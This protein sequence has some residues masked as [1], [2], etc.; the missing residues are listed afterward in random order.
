LSTA[1]TRPSTPDLRATGVLLAGLVVTSA[2]GKG[3]TP[4][5]LAHDYAVGVGL[6]ILASLVIDYRR[7]LRN[8]V[9]ADLMAIGSLYFLT[10]FEFLFPQPEFNDLVTVEEVL[11]ALT[12]CLL[13]FAGLAI[14]RHLAPAAPRSLQETLRRPIS[15]QT[16]IILYTVCF[17]GGY[18]HMLLAVDF[19]VFEMIHYFMTPRFTQPW[20]R[21]KYGDWKALIG[22]LGMVLY[23]I[24]PIAGIVLAKRK[25]F[26]TGQKVY[27][28]AAFLFTLF[29]GFT[30]GTRNIFATYL[31]TFLVANAFVTNPDKKKELVGVSALTGVLMLAA[32]VVM[33]EF[34]T[35]GFENYCSGYRE[36]QEKKEKTTFFVDYNLYV[37]AKLGDVF[38]EQHDFLGWEIPYLAIIRPIPRAIW[39]GKPEGLSFSIE[40]AVG[41]KGLTLASSFV[42]EAYISGGLFGV[43]LTGLVFGSIAGWWNRLGRPDNSAFGHLIFSSAFFAAVI[44]MR[45]MFVFTT[46]I[47]PTIAALMF[48][49]WLIG[50]RAAHRAPPEGGT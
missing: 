18:F 30:S 41:V 19:N 14:G 40:D 9:R 33:L 47:L 24:P 39:P 3:T 28:A 35:I 36:I 34:R 6:S 46:A 2:V 7:N 42:G 49:N 20:G 27:V 23:L 12:A 4:V 1:E 10:L 21:G 11:P 15:P 17:I 29:Y 43:L 5:E 44:S 45:S 38:P 16:L 32:T 25:D 37:I 22:E 50:R 26:S 48:G 31:A 8:L 13:G